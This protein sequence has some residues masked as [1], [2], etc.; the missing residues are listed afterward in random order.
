ME[1]R[2]L[3]ARAVVSLMLSAILFCMPI[4]AFFANRTNTIEV[5][6][7]DTAEQKTES[8]S[9]AENTVTPGNGREE[10]S[11]TDTGEGKTA[12]KCTC[13]EKCSQY[14]VDEDCEVCAKNYKEC[15]Y[16]NPSVKITINTSSG[17]HND[18]TKVIVK[19]EDTIVSGNF[20]VQ[21]VKAKVGQNGSWKWTGKS[22]SR[23]EWKLDRYYRGYV[24]RD[25]RKQ[26]YLCAGHRPEGQDL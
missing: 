26:H 23:A 19:V 11:G 25:F 24:H 1:N 3:S 17:W 21:T 22:A 4:G 10:N 8:A 18:T 7:E 13:K 9:D 12:A 16:I 15:T 6:A 2:K 14:A 5:H 20:T